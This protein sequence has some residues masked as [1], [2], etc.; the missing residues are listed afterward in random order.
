[1]FMGY[2]W[3]YHGGGNYYMVRPDCG[4]SSDPLALFLSGVPHLCVSKFDSIHVSQVCF[5]TCQ[6]NG[7]YEPSQHVLDDLQ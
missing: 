5:W 3:L 1:M 7:D 4:S 2:A 6:T